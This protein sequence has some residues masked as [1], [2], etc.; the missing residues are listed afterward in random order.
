MGII[1]LS[2][3]V[4]HSWCVMWSLGYGRSRQEEIRSS[5]GRQVCDLEVGDLHTTALRPVVCQYLKCSRCCSA[6]LRGMISSA[7]HEYHHLESGSHWAWR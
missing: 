7:G 2:F 6:S 5:P 1:A 4:L 3:I